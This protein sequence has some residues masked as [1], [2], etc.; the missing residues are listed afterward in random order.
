MDPQRIIRIDASAGSGKTYQLSMRYLRLVQEIFT[1]PAGRGEGVTR[2]A[3]RNPEGCDARPNDISAILAITFTNKAAM[4]MKERILLLLKKALLINEPPSDLTISPEQAKQILFHIIRNFSD[5]NVMTIDAFM[6]N[7]LR[8]FA[9]E[10]G[11]LPDYE[12]RFNTEEI[13]N[14]ALDRLM[15]RDEAQT[16]FS[17]FLDH[18]LTVERAAGFNPE[19]MIRNALHEIRRQ[20]FHPETLPPD[21]GSHFDEKAAWEAL[22]AEIAAFYRELWKIQDS[23]DCFKKGSFKPED[24]LEKLEEKEFPPWMRDGRPLNSL[25]KKN[26]FCPDLEALSERLEGIRE[27]LSRY[28]T[29]LEVHKFQRVLEVFRLTREEETR[30]YRELNQFDGSRL[31]DRV[32]GLLGAYPGGGVPAAFC[33]L[34]ERYVHHLIDEFQD[35]SRSQWKGMVPLIENSLSEGGS[36]FYVGDTKQAIYGW[37]GGDYALM[38]EACKV[39]PETWGKE[40]KPTSLETN[41]R[42]RRE[43]VD[44]Y[45]ALFRH[46][47]FE[48]ALST[49]LDDPA[50]LTE[51]QSVYENSKQ[52]ARPGMEGGYIEARFFQGTKD[53]PDPQRPVREA[54]FQALERARALYPDREILILA[55]KNDEIETLAGW[56]F[57]H[58]DT[59]PFVTEQSL[60][61]FALSPVKSILNLL[62]SLA[63]PGRH[64]Y[65][66]AVIQDGLFGHLP[67]GTVTEILA[68]YDKKAPFDVY[69]R[70]RFPEIDAA[71]FSPLRKRAVQLSPYELTREILARFEIPRAF[72]GSRPLTDR[73]LEQILIQEQKGVADLAKLLEIFYETTEETHLTLP[74]TPDVLRLMT[75]HKAKGLEADVVILPFLNWPMKPQDYHEIFEVAEN[76][77]AYLSRRLCDYNERAE[78][79]RREIYKKHFVESF[80]LMYVA[81]TRAREALFLMVPPGG[82]GMN[83]GTIFRRLAEFH[84]YL[85]PNEEGFTMGTLKRHGAKTEERPER[86]GGTED[87]RRQAP[88]PAA[89]AVRAHLRLATESGDDQWMDARAR[90]LGNIAHAA[91]ATVRVLPADA[92]PETE[93]RRALK[94]AVRRMGLII[95]KKE[96]SLLERLLAMTLRDLDEFFTDVDAAWTEKEFISREGKIVRVDRLVLKDGAYTVVEFKTGKR[97]EAHR[98]QVAYYLQVVKSLGVME[99]CHGVLYYLETGEQF[100]V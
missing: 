50:Y 3:C 79:R 78:L 18:L 17:G 60:K 10:T 33:R 74:E 68:G 4:E 41:W 67:P 62:S 100:H 97:E 24:H 52:D 69:V 93:A 29:D 28:Y 95:G 77:Y 59:I 38:K 75:I 39:M 81:L 85:G 53:L 84:E 9:V 35:T 48:P 13:Y 87:V 76:R 46:T 2:D 44:F 83:V 63:L 40:C 15:E 99:P 54:F 72:P 7:I 6:N 34:G 58:P 8:A 32:Q 19:S 25:L 31:P 89:D 5:F 94:R 51:L 12:L 30:I 20:R 43:L 96:H 98:A 70:E 65:L 73:L 90:R 1:S 82:R 47:D 92:T 56:L 45:N 26:R 55:R 80:N 91:L 71:F 57:E 14:L 86:E 11:R 64:P 22:R 23:H 88:Q 42:S 66:H 37:R 49:L 16:L 21:S 36:F 61:L 27:G